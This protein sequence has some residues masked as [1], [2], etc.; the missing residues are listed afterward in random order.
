MDKL[1]DTANLD[2]TFDKHKVYKTFPADWTSEMKDAA[3]N[4]CLKLGIPM[5][6]CYESTKNMIEKMRK[7]FSSDDN[8]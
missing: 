6:R 2:Y 3:I 7:A 4:Y 8:I 5:Y 1:D